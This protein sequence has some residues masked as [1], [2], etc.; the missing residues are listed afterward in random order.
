[1]TQC[2]MNTLCCM[3]FFS[4]G[5]AT[6]LHFPQTFDSPEQSPS[7]TVDFPMHI[8]LAGI[9]H[10]NSQCRELGQM[11]FKDNEGPMRQINGMDKSTLSGPHHCVKKHVLLF[12]FF[13]FLINS[14]LHSS[15]IYSVHACLSAWVNNHLL[16]A[17]P[18]CLRHSMTTREL[19]TLRWGKPNTEVVKQDVSSTNYH[20]VPEKKKSLLADAKLDLWLI[21][22]R[23]LCKT[24]IPMG[25][26]GL[27]PLRK[28][29]KFE[30]PQIIWHVVIRM[31]NIYQA[32]NIC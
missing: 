15:S 3:T 17:R 30:E 2:Y 21:T 27:Q 4:L 29:S 24:Q 26:M 18:W 5:Y 10:V 19:E 28:K 22:G 31:I 25:G 6:V 9:C 20:S 7:N 32:Q 8:S 1:M 14:S 12:F 16:S 23:N 13:F 11:Y